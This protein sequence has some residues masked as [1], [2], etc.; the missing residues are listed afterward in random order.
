MLKPLVPDTTKRIL[1]GR[2]VTHEEFQQAA[3]GIAFGEVVEGDRPACWPM[4]ASLSMGVHRKD[5][6]AAQEEAKRLGCNVTFDKNGDLSVPDK[7][8]WRRYVRAHNHHARN[9]GYSDP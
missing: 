2:E 3:R 5:A 1:N 6:A 7:A 4:N 9:G 8:T